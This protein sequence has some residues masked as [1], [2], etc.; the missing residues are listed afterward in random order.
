MFYNLWISVVL[1]W[2]LKLLKISKNNF[3]IIFYINISTFTSVLPAS[4]V[5]V[6]FVPSRPVPTRL[7]N[8]IMKIAQDHSTTLS[9]AASPEGLDSA[10][11]V[12]TF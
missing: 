5:V 2:L 4:S 6:V 7:Q 1:D 9:S 12:G 11:A 8:F 3:T 10:R